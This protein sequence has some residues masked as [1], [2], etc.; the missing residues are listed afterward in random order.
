MNPL[1]S[2]L[3]FSSFADGVLG[4][5]AGGRAGSSQPRTAQQGMTLT[6]AIDCRERH[7]GQ[8]AICELRPIFPCFAGNIRHQTRVIQSLS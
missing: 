3:G 2:R 7:L 4:I 1:C 8:K 5:G 6:A